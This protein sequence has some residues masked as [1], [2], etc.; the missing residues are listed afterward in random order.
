ML[1]TP[2]EF[3]Q[4]SDIVRVGQYKAHAPA[5]TEEA[6]GA[7]SSLG[8]ADR[9]DETTIAGKTEEIACYSALRFRAMMRGISGRALGVEKR[10]YFNRLWTRDT[11]R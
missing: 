11:S 3:R 2:S 8:D 5:L 1:A 10:L 7:S 6:S 4:Q 9:G